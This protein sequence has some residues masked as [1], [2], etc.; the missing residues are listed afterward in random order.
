MYHK[1]IWLLFI[2]IQ[3]CF[4]LFVDGNKNIKRSPALKVKGRETRMKYQLLNHF[5]SADPAIQKTHD[6][7]INK[8]GFAEGTEPPEGASHIEN[9][10]ALNEKTSVGDSLKTSPVPN[11]K[12]YTPLKTAER[13]NQTVHIQNNTS[14]GEEQ[15]D[16]KIC[17]DTKEECLELQRLFDDIIN[18]YSGTW[19]F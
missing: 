2:V 4:N 1:N 10:I 5:H 12:K 18:A 16:Y 8:P 17:N 6:K 19:R 13:K 14:N 9:F 3:H 15:H 7:V 11:R